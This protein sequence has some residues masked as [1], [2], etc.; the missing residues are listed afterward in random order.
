MTFNAGDTAPWYDPSAH[1][2]PT[3]RTNAFMLGV[4]KNNAEACL[5]L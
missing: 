2:T 3:E 5:A 4:T 1:G